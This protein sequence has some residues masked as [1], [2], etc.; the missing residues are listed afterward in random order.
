MEDVLEL[1]C[2]K[3]MP[4]PRTMLT[5]LTALRIKC[6]IS[7]WITM[8]KK[9][10]EFMG[11][12][13]LPFKLYMS[14]YYT[15]KVR[16]SV[17]EQIMRLSYSLECEHCGSRRR[18]IVDDFMKKRVCSLC[19][20]D[21]YVSN[22][23]LYY[24]YGLDA[25]NVVHR[26]GRF[27]RFLPLRKY[28]CVEIYSSDSMDALFAPRKIMFFWRPDLEKIFDLEEL[29]RRQTR[30]KHT[31]QT[32]SLYVKTLFARSWDL[33]HLRFNE[34]TR[35]KIMHWVAGSNLLPGEDGDDCHLL[36]RRYHMPFVATN[37]FHFKL[38]AE[39]FKGTRTE[40]REM[41]HQTYRVAR[42]Q[43]WNDNEEV[44]DSASA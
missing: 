44:C 21:L 22:Y 24:T 4:Q 18:L 16:P 42:L 7:F 31:A 28:T 2:L 8:W 40:F 9:H 39:R 15:G 33:S 32:L 23:V 3:L 5:F 12:G 30:R 25:H 19:R 20:Q 29:R 6:S 41:V 10:A 1:I 11:E 13:E 14:P 17:Y 26:W 43:W 27:V 37:E 36:T 34:F 38:L 35:T